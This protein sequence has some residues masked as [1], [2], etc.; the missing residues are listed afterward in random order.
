MP[1]TLMTRE[2]TICALATA[3]GGAIGII[4]VSGNNTFQI[5]NKIFTKDLTAAKANT[6]NYG[7]IINAHNDII[8]EVLISV[9]RAPHS[10]TGEDSAEI[11][12]H[13][14][15]Y[16]LNTVLE[17]LISNGATLASP[18]EFTQRA[19]LNGKID[20][21][22]AE[23][24]A[25]LISSTTKATHDIAISQLK[26]HFSTE[27]HTLR[28][29]L[30]HLT[31]LLELELDFSDHEE[32]EFADRNELL[33][34]AEKTDKRITSLAQSFETGKALKAG[35]PVALIGNTNVGKSTLLNKLLK[36]E[37][38]IVSDIHGTTRDTVEDVIT[39]NG[40]QFRFIDTAGIRQT[41]DT[42]EQIGIERTYQSIERA[43]III[44]LIDDIP[45]PT[46]I[47]D[48]Q[49]RL[50]NKKLIIAFNKVDLPEIKEKLTIFQ[51]TTSSAL[52][53]PYTSIEISA[54]GDYNI[55]KLEQVI[56]EAANI[57]EIKENDIIITSARH[58]EALNH[59]HRN[60]SRVIEGLAN[61][62]SGDLISEDL[63]L[64]LNDLSE[65]TGGAITPQETLN[66]IF[67]HFCIGK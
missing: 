44:W 27:L 34:L 22:Q 9:F 59:A 51:S 43:K 4:R 15:Q 52:A 49:N 60:I 6:I 32:L 8:D 58:Y 2:K 56:Y 24:V 5:I 18:G 39:I 13:A 38:A 41:D 61:G 12:C 31:T 48:I 65:I 7:H 25:D 37:R 45:S 50:N 17:L 14:S 19:Y 33:E 64:A 57:P 55:E 62:L 29:Q 36:E 66:N 53:H 47:S 20:L 42:I 1:Q 30:L 67:A 16:I 10:Y 23:A 26:G 35:I 40:I 54:K 63:R 3:A 46:I 21:S 11:S 28:D